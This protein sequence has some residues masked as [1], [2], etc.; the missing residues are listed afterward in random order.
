V[1]TGVGP[2]SPVWLL[3]RGDS[4]SK[5]PDAADADLKGGGTLEGYMLPQRRPSA[6]KNKNKDFDRQNSKG[7]LRV[8]KNNTA[9]NE[10]ILTRSRQSRNETRGGMHT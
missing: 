2:I 3:R 8:V 9:A 10:I 5:S 4:G 6:G 7:S 1:L